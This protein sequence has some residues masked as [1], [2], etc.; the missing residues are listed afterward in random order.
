VEK[1]AVKKLNWYRSDSGR[2]DPSWRTV[3]GEASLL[4]SC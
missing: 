4:G 3:I 2:I 1:L